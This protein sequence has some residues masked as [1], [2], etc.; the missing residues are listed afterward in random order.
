VPP[1]NGR[2][3]RRQL[4]YREL[5]ERSRHL[6]SCLGLHLDG[7]SVVAIMLPRSTEQLYVSQLAVLRAGAAFCCID[8]SFPDA[9]VAY[10]LR[11]S[12]AVV[13]LTDHEGAQR[14]SRLGMDGVRIVNVDQPV[15]PLQMPPGRVLQTCPS[16]DSLAYQIYT[17]GTTGQPKGVMIEH[18]SICNLIAGNL[19]CFQ[20]SETDRVSQV[21]SAAWDSSVEEIWLA[22]S[23]GATLVVMDEHVARSGPDIV[24][25]LCRERITMY[26]SV[27]TQLRSTGCRN[28]AARLPLLRY[29]YVGGEA[30][31]QDLADLWAPCCRMFNGYGPTETTVVS[32]RA[33]INAEEPVTIGRPVPGMEAWV[34]DQELVEVGPGQQGEL[35][36]GGIGLARGYRNSPDLTRAKFVEHPT[37]GRIYRTGDLVSR[38][39]QGALV[40]H[41]RLDS[42]LKIRGY[43]IELEEIEAHLASL[44]GVREAA[45]VARRTGGRDELVAFVVVDDAADFPGTRR[46]QAQLASVLP[47]YMVPA[48]IGTVPALPTSVA[49][50]LDRE[51]LPD[52]PEESE[53]AARVRQPATELE[54]VVLGAFH[55][56]LCRQQPISADENFFLDLGGDSLG[57]ALVISI[58][59]DTPAT[60]ALTVSDLYENPTVVGLARRATE[61]IEAQAREVEPI[62]EVGEERRLLAV[63]LIQGV[64]LLGLS[65]A[66]SVI[67]YLVAFH[68]VLPVTEFLGPTT[69]LLLLPPIAVLSDLLYLPL[70]VLLLAGL[71]RLFIG[72]YRPVKIPVWSPTYLRHWVV[73]LAAR[74]V[75][76]N[77]FAGTVFASWAL[78]CLGAR[79]GQRV[80][81]HRGVALGGGGWDLLDIGDDVTLSHE[82]ALRLTQLSAGYLHVGPIRIG[83]RAT[84]ERRSGMAGFTAIEEEGYLG[85]LASLQGG[86]V[87]GP[88]ERWDGVPARKT[89]LSPGRATLD[90]TGRELSPVAHGVGLLLARSALVLLL[91][92]PLVCVLAGAVFVSGLDGPATLTSLEDVL[93][94]GDSALVLLGLVVV[95]APMGLFTTATCCRALGAVPAGTISRWSPEYI[96]VWLKTDLVDMSCRVLSGTLMWPYWLRLAGMKVG[97][98]CEISTIFDVVPELV[99]I[100]D[101]SFFADG[102]YLGGPRVHRGHVT[103]AET[104]LG[105]RTFLGNHVV[106]EGGHTLPAGVLLGVCTVSHEQIQEN[107]SWFGN[108]SFLLPRREVVDMDR[109]F[110]HEPGLIRRVTRV[111][112]EQLRFLLPILPVVLAWFWLEQAYAYSQAGWPLWTLVGLL[113]TL[114]LATVAVPG[115]VNIAG[116]WLLLGRVS[117]GRHALWSCW[118][119]RWDF[120]YMLWSAY[121]RPF[122]VWLEGTLLLGWYL[123]AVGMKI[124]RRVVLGPGFAQVVDPDMLEIHDDATVSSFFQAHTF[125]DRV[126]KID[127]VTIR[128]GATVQMGTVLLYGADIGE[129]SVVGSH[130]VVMKKERLQARLRYCGCPTRL[131]AFSSARP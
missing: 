99:E 38:D 57:A 41:G 117:P 118:C 122:L 19:D 52:L 23:V 46:L 59:R 64:V 9:R 104:S 47:P 56:G 115:L 119:G 86:S 79:V 8:R 30:L 48:R 67:A 125:E 49:G 100:G 109:R 95:Q 112:W 40:Y 92:V 66:G 83:S 120:H 93:L 91:T 7:E 21:S 34:L 116:K 39:A 43:R 14:V 113:A 15:Q 88:K 24:E 68:V 54:S 27:P 28:P 51:R 131:Q 70:S 74:F 108:P 89:G 85:P 17:S 22:F 20:L 96:R 111:F 1:G 110:T 18:R 33:E 90:R 63:T 26:I 124:G 69:S 80:H 13:L 130:S 25:W 71:K 73:Q 36:M 55:E 82:S 58:L 60:S 3:A 62:E 106:I 87:V 84:L 53:V 61:A 98:G 127:R 29:L 37:F 4:S 5:D 107:E 76:W 10:V 103:L 72:R 50:R 78:R 45:C 114:G 129:G 2:H 42:Q 81:V 77:Q 94:R 12:G 126:L 35:C 31:P 97:R 128:S 123:R 6:T 101:E 32:V 11:D 75:P 105:N 44:D 65:V 121:A 102:V 16:P